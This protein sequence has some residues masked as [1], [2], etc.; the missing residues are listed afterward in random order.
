M[1]ELVI[2]AD[3]ENLEK[4]VSFL[5]AELEKT[6]C[7]I[8]LKK[9]LDIVIEEI[10]VN[11]AYYAYGEGSGD[12]TIQVG[13]EDGELTLAFIDQGVPYNPLAKEDPDIS[14]PKAKRKV[15]GLGIFIVKQCMDDIQ[16]RN[17][18]GKNILTL[19]KKLQ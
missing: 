11:I 17:E 6:G 2:E 15:G 13:F 10:F 9:Q 8:K 16:Y 3:S 12:A 14:L 4:V 18:D 5:D 1:K 7:D 19:S